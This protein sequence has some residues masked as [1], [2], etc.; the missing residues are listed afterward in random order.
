VSASYLIHSVAECESAFSEQE[1]QLENRQIACRNLGNLL[2]GIGRFDEA[3]IWHSFAL[4]PEPD[5]TDLHCQLGRLYAQESKWHQAAAAFEKALEIRPDALHIHS[6]LAQIYGHIGNK[7]A[8]IESWYKA[9]EHNPEL[10]NVQGYYKLG[11]AFGKQ[12]KIDQAMFCL[13]KACELEEDFL[14]AHYDLADIWFYQGKLD[15]AQTQ[16]QK[17]ITQDEQEYKAHFK[18]GNTYLRKR[19]YDEAIA[20]FYKTIKVAPEFPWAY[21]DLVKTYLL[22]GKWDQAI[23]T[24]HSILNL[25]EEFPWLYIQLGDAFAKKGRVLDA[26]SSFKKACTLRGWQ[27]CS[28]RNYHF[29]QD[30]FSYRLALWQ[31][32]M[33]PVMGQKNLRILELGSSQGMSSCWLLDTVLTDESSKLICLDT[34]FDPKLAE[35]LQTTGRK[36]Q[37]SLIKS[38]IRESRELLAKNSFDLIIL[39]DRNRNTDHAWQNTQAMWQMLKVNGV[40]IFNDYGW[41][42]PQDPQQNPKVGID[43]FLKSVPQQFEVITH[44]AQSFQF[45]IKRTA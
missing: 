24:C 39:Q 14:P 10:I 26:V 32:L 28:D 15:D 38:T 1:D 17:I 45:I 29:T 19:Q 33:K 23:S 12:N 5:L 6:N 9:L 35:N 43:K 22:M 4:D 27:E 16:Y 34:Q 7:L 25:V 21:R 13:E 42:N 3:V 18:L 20:E 11:K 30:T 31:P 37:V 41:T 40:A 44:A 36:N 2:Q 8:E